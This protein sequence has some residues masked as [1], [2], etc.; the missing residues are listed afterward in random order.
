MSETTLSTTTEEVKE[1][2]LNYVSYGLPVIPLCPPDHRGMNNSH[3]QR[4]SSPGKSPIIPDWQKHEHTTEQ[5]VKKW[6]DKNQYL[7]I[8]MPLGRNSGIVGIDVDGH[9]NMDVLQDIC[10]GD[11]PD[12]WE[13]TTGN[14]YRIMYQLPPGLETKKYVVELEEGEIALL[15]DGQQTVLPP[16]NHPKGVAYTWTMGHSPEDIPISTAPEWLI[17]RIIAEDKKQELEEKQQSEPPDPVEDGNSV[18]PDDW[19]KDIKQGG[20]NNHLTR[21]AGSL[22]ARGTIPKEEVLMFLKSW[23]EEHCEPP[24]PDHEIEKM[25]EGL[26][27][28]EEMKNAKRGRETEQGK[29]GKK[30]FRATPVAKAFF[31]YEQKEGREWAYSTT[32]GDFYITNIEEGPWEIVM[33]EEVRKRIRSFLIDPTK[34]GDIG[35]DSQH[36]VRETVDAAKSL[37][38]NT[39]G[40]II[41]DLGEQVAQGNYDLLEYIH[42]DNG[43]LEWRKNEMHP[44][45]PNFRTTVKLPIPWEGLDAECPTWKETLKEWIPDKGTRKFLQEYIGLCLIPDTRYRTA[46]FLFGEGS[47]GKGLFLDTVSK[48]FGKSLTAI[49]LHKLNNRFEVGYI[50]NKLINICGDIDSQY[51]KDTGTIKALIGGDILRGERKHGRSFNF[52]PVAR[53]LFSANRLPRVADKTHAWYSRWRF[54][55]FPNTFPVNPE[56]KINF[57]KKVNKELP[58]ILAWAVKGLMRLEYNNKFTEG[59]AMKKAEDEYKQENDS[60]L[61]FTSTALE[62]VKHEGQETSLPQRVVWRTYNEWCEQEG[63]KPVGK[64][65]FGKRLEGCGF[66]RGRRSVRGISGICLLGVK[67]VDEWKST[68]EQYERLETK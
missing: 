48:L 12:T 43:L 33:M 65:E 6:F 2:A 31:K 66:E 4:C 42:V 25:V 46:A 26:F 5:Q 18:T 55:E 9:D 16:S 49:P 52:R 50:R 28:S 8:G 20:R 32:D 34:G 53:L 15:C 64:R 19:K 56:F 63:L 41:F 39:E 47:N 1:A 35:W 58:G 29:Q 22:I 51:L 13:Y 10:K 24:L 30:T 54:I 14:G 27:L 23:N 21:L 60:V 45:D 40:D 57:N 59:E 17:E 36:Y 7:N 38:I 44:W 62:Q 61:Y 3:R 68:Y 67:V 37:L 11:L